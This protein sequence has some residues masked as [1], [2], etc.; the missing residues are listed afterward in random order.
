MSS[1]YERELRAILRG[2]RKILEKVTKT[3][4]AE[5]KEKYMSILRKPFIVVRAAGSYGVDLVAV[6]DDI[7][8]LVEIKSSNSDTIRF[9]RN[10]I[11]KKQ[12]FN[13]MD[14]C[15]RAGILPIYAFRLK[16]RRGDT[17]RM[18]TLDIKNLK[19]KA[20]DVH[21]TVPKIKVSKDNNF[22]MR[23][24]EGMQLSDFIHLLSK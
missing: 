4:T 5:E 24:K 13:I 11:L 14:E 6:R 10:E 3:C 1:K 19:G 18:F 17:W 22:V 23:W 21:K 16:R 8:F 7:S 2:D 9:S 20:K 15:E 12:A